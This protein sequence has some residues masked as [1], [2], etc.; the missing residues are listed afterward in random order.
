MQAFFFFQ[1]WKAGIQN[2]KVPFFFFLVY[3]ILVQ[4]NCW[5]RV[6][7]DHATVLVP[8]FMQ[9]KCAIVCTV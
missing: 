9:S 4:G 3:G 1:F 7:W 8:P 6:L 2:S 5:S